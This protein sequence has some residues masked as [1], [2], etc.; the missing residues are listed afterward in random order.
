MRGFASFLLLLVFALILIRTAGLRTAASDAALFYETKS[1][2]IEKRY[3]TEQDAKNAFRQ[4]LRSEKILDR[5]SALKA[6][7]ARI[8]TFEVF[9]ENYY[10]GKG[11]RT[12]FWLGGT[13]A[14]EI[15]L[16]KKRMLEEKKPLKCQNCLDLNDT[17]LD[18]NGKPVLAAECFLD[19][20]NGETKISRNGLANCP[21][22]IARFAVSEKIVFGISTYF[23]GEKISAVMIMP[24]GFG[25]E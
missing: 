18:W 23:P 4:L 25:G 10:E 11:A 2:A 13:D 8:A 6:I 15:A 12:D 16:L 5:T 21:D 19:Y 22:F 3:Y 20:G 24:E 1:L 14:N 17:T 7:A 9:A